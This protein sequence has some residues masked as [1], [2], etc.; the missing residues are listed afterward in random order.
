MSRLS[1][2]TVEKM[3]KK[4]HNNKKVKLGGWEFFPKKSTPYKI[5][6]VNNDEL[7]YHGVFKNKSVSLYWAREDTKK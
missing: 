4:Q 7:I 1:E 2:A 6:I 5:Y 3:L